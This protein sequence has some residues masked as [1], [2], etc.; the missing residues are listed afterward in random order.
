M[1]TGSSVLRNLVRSSRDSKNTWQTVHKKA[2]KRYVKTTLKAKNI[3]IKEW[4][5]F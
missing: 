1:E 3:K 4:K 2:T 5:K